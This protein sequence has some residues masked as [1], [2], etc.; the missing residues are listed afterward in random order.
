MLR[1][2]VGGRVGWDGIGVDSWEMRWDGID[3]A[4]VWSCRL[5]GYVARLAIVWREGIA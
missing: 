2:V 4:W 3:A 1:G 5:S